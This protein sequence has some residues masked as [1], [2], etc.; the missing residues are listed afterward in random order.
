MDSQFE[1][2]VFC[3]RGRHSPESSS[4]S[5]RQEHEPLI[6]LHLLREMKAG[7]QM[8]S[9]LKFTSGA[10]VLPPTIHGNLYEL[11][12]SGSIQKCMA[13]GMFSRRIQIHSNGQ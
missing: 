6:T 13:R 11:N 9:I 3:G 1:G 5:W 8:T 2:S 7:S 12:I 4:S 10:W